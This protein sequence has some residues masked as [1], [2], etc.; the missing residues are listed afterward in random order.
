MTNSFFALIS[1]MRHIKRWGLMRNSYQENI[2]EHSHMTAVI[3]H[4]LAVIRRDV[5][6]RSA[7]PA[8]AAAAALFHDAPEIITGDLPTPVKYL[9]A[10]ISGA[11]K[12]VEKAAGEK[13]LEMLPPELRPEYGRLLDCRDEDTL[14]LVKAADK[15]SAYIKCVEEIRAGN[16]EFRSAEQQIREALEQLPMPEVKYFIKNFMPSFGMTLDELTKQQE[17][18][19]VR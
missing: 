2:Q 3:A 6:G 7:D 14:S 13:L 9:N 8:A 18:T 19:V 10:E 1:R 17:G 16:S 4:A 11:Y 5:L 12:A 15:L